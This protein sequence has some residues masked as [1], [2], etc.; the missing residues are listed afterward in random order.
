MNKKVQIIGPVLMLII[1]LDDSCK[2]RILL[3]TAPE[4]AGHK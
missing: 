1:K 4:L 3:P 2:S